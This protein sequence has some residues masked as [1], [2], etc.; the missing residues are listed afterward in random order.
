MNNRIKLTGKIEFEP[1]DKTKKHKGQSSWKKMAMV[2]ISGD[3]CEYYAWFLQ[4]RYNLVL[5]KPLRGGHISFINDSMRDLSL[6]GVR[7]EEETEALWE[8][9]KTKWHGK[10]IEIVLD[11]DPK[12][13]DRIWWLN[14]PNEERG[15]LQS[16]RTELGLGRPYWGMH[17]SIGYANEKMIEHSEYI[18]SLIKNGFI[19]YNN[20]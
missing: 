20:G 5:N 3:I 14:I 17:M 12:T 16:I 13:D 11:I 1:S 7:T 18:H 10:E 15:V 8:S 4:K 9:V 19:K 2:L 6:N